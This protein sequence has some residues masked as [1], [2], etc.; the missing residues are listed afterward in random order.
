MGPGGMVAIRVLLV[1]S[2]GHRRSARN[3]VRALV[4]L[5]FLIRLTHAEFGF[6]QRRR[7][8]RM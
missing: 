8:S 3:F 5:L 2:D 6:P 1:R 4:P 7:C